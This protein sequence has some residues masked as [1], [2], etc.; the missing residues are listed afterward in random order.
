MQVRL[1]SRYHNGSDVKRRGAKRDEPGL[2]GALR[3]APRVLVV[4]VGELV[5]VGVVLMHNHRLV[6][7]CSRERHHS[8]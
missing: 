6:A 1:D 7:L 2:T 8:R 4:F 5:V 3:A